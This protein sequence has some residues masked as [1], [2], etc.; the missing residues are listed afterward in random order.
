MQSSGTGFAQICFLLR[1]PIGHLCFIL[2]C[3]STPPLLDVAK[4]EEESYDKDK[5]RNSSAD[6]DAGFCSSR[7]ARRGSFCR[8][9]RG[10]GNGSGGARV[11]ATR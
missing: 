11:A 4:A 8:D 10:G 9:G 3:P 5:T 1:F 6:T 7:Q 2:R